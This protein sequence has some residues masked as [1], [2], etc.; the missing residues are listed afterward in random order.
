MSAVYS[1]DVDGRRVRSWDSVDDST[2]Y[3]YSGLNVID[4]VSGGVHEKH[5]YTGGMHIASNSSGTVEYY[6]VDHLGST[7]LKMDGAGDVVYESNYEPYGPG[8]GEEGSEDYRYTGKREDPTGLYYFGAR[9]YDPVTGRFTTRDTVMGDLSDPQ[10]LN[11]YSYCRNNPHKYTDPDGKS[12]GH[13][14]SEVIY[15]AMTSIFSL[16]L[17]GATTTGILVMLPVLMTYD[18]Y[19]TYQR[20]RYKGNQEKQSY[21]MEFGS[22]DEETAHKYYLAGYNAALMEKSAIGI[23][24]FEQIGL[25]D[26]LFHLNLV[27]MGVETDITLPDFVL[28]LFP[29]LIENGGDPLTDEI[30]T[31]LLEE[32]CEITQR[33]YHQTIHDK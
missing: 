16:T 5:Y 29:E 27:S 30:A 14:G 15:P 10:S 22:E 32:L 20:A 13:I 31:I 23:L 17:A 8:C 7:R 19:R 25:Y 18:A 2:D 1:Y 26:V 12:C 24:G 21:I 4:E 6:H 28:D 3:V 11:R 9:Y 33:V